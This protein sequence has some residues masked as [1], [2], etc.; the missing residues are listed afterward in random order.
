MWKGGCRVKG[1][2][3]VWKGGDG[4]EGGGG[5]RGGEKGKVW[6]VE[7][8]RWCGGRGWRKGRGEGRGEGK[9]WRVEGKG[10]YKHFVAISCIILC[11]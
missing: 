2:G 8:R 11:T 1:R 10:S 5:E 6:R 9:V 7:G 3:V 4:V